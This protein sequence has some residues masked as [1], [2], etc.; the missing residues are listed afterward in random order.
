MII[1]KELK[2]YDSANIIFISQNISAIS[3]FFQKKASETKSRHIIIEHSTGI[4]NFNNQY[5][6]LLK[7]S[8][9]NSEFYT[10]SKSLQK[11]IKETYDVDTNV[12]LNNISPFWSE[13][14]NI[15]LIKKTRFR[16]IK[17]ILFIGH[18]IERKNIINLISK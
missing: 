2:K 11:K 18:L 3:C 6:N 5:N 15:E 17:N 1:K 8:I 12:T 16:K 4:N 10:V 9:L 7:K 13:I 14:A